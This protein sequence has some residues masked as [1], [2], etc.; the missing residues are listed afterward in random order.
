M[1]RRELIV[2]GS[3]ALG[4]LSAWSCR[5][6]SAAQS[7]SPTADVNLLVAE[8]GVRVVGASSSHDGLNAEAMVP[9]LARLAEPGVTP[10]DFYWCTADSAP[11]PHWVLLDLQRPTWLTTLVFNTAVKD[12]LAYP[13][14]S[15]RGLEVWAGMQTPEALQRVAAFELERGRA[16]QAVRLVPLQARWLKFVVTSNWGHP[17]WTE[18]NATA[19][20][21]DGS[22]PTAVGGALDAQGRVDLYGLYFD[23]A[24]ATLRAESAPVLDEIQA[25]QRAHPGERLRIEGHT[26][27][28]GSVG[29]NDALSLAR[30]QA[31]V[32]AL[33]ARGLP[34]A[35]LDTVGHGARFPVASNTTDS[36]RARNRRVSVVRVSRP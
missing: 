4:L 22:R 6:A 10:E 25:W 24:S 26:D 17:V 23:F 11:F 30:A 12:E 3:S 9:A 15:A 16:R 19:A 33:V 18:L 13:G 7:V 20:H 28:V 14:I 29:A 8:R 32:E 36:G 5:R 2:H 27:A 34:R 35:Q 1:N 21:D 31:V